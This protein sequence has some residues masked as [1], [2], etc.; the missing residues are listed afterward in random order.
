MITDGSGGVARGSRRGSGARRLAAGAAVVSAAVALSSWPVAPTGA[1]AAPTGPERAALRAAHTATTLRDGRVLV[2]GGCVVDGC[3]RATDETVVIAGD[4][5]RSAGGPRLV[6]ARDA[7]TASLLPTG[8][9]LIAGGFGAEGV[10]PLR[11][12]EVVDLARRRSSVA[13]SL[14]VGRGG[15]AA[16]VRPDGTVVVIGGWIAPRTYTSSVEYVRAGRVARGPSL[17]WAADALDAVT[18]RDGRV[19]VTGGQVASGVGTARAAL[20]DPASGAWTEVAPMR[21]ARFKHTSVVLPDGSVLVIGGTSDDR[22]LLRTTERFD[23]RTGRFTAGPSMT[24]PRYKLAGGAVVASDGRVVVAGGG[25]TVE[26]IDVRS[27]RSQVLA[28]FPTR[29]SFATANLLTTNRVLVL[30]GYDDEIRL[31]PEVAVIDVG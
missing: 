13:G 11:S 14:A 8:G 28:T 18:L 7:H 9:V 12:I 10:P 5:T 29:G 19:L 6:E 23:P 26:A 16:A 2:A 22:T 1:V 31:R 17:P 27:A 20:L 15:H 21:T 3:S 24:E 4:G 25:R 30:G